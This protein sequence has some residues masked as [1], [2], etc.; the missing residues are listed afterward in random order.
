MSSVLLCIYLQPI[1]LLKWG[2]TFENCHPFRS[3]SVFPTYTPKIWWNMIIL[4]IFW[5]FWGI[6][7]TKLVFLEFFHCKIQQ[8]LHLL[9]LSKKIWWKKVSTCCY[10]RLDLLKHSVS[11]H[12][13]NGY[14]RVWADKCC[15]KS[16]IPTSWSISHPF[17]MPQCSLKALKE[18]N[19]TPHNKIHGNSKNV[20]E[21]SKL[22]CVADF[23]RKFQLDCM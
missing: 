13:Y 20:K 16:R 21:I 14:I 17:H 6:S 19:A 11:G 22:N 2:K 5:W 1:R 9:S 3:Y 4:V 18:E 7:E 12:G 15:C 8:K 23:K 10:R